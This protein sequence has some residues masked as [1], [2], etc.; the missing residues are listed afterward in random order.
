MPLSLVPHDRSIAEKCVQPLNDPAITKKPCPV[1]VCILL[2]RLIIKNPGHIYLYSIRSLDH[3]GTWPYK[4]LYSIGWLDHKETWPYKCLYSIESLD[5]METW[6]YK[7]LYSIGSL[8][9]METWP[10]YCMSVSILFRLLDK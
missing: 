4:C 8:D 9:H 5:H 3:K 2:D 6:P 1:Y 7:C 10:Y